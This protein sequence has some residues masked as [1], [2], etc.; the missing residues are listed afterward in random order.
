MCRTIAWLVAVDG[1]S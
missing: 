1:M